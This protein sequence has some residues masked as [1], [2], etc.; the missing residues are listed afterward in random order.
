MTSMVK[1]Q[2]KKQARLIELD[3]PRERAAG[4]VSSSSFAQWKPLSLGKDQN[5]TAACIFSRKNQATAVI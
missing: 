5:Q 1:P 3:P 2:K 4:T